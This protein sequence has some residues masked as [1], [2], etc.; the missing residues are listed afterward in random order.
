MNCK[1]QKIIVKNSKG[2]N[3]IYKKIKITETVKKNQEL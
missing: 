1:E 3:S 2:Q